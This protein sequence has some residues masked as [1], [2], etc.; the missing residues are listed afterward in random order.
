VSKIKPLSVKE[1]DNID[2]ITK[3]CRKAI[4]EAI[5]N[6]QLSF[7]T[8]R[9]G[10]G[11]LRSLLI[12]AESSQATIGNRNYPVFL[13]TEVNAEL[14]WLGVVLLFGFKDRIQYLESISLVV[15]KGLAFDNKVPILRAEWDCGSEYLEA[16]HGQPHWHIYPSA[17]INKNLESDEILEALTN[18]HEDFNEMPSNQ[19]LPKFH[20]A[21]ATKWHEGS[22]T[23][24]A[25]LEEVSS[26][27]AWLQ[28][29]INYTRQQLIYSWE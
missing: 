2:D 14:F 28:S 10:R 12:G 26:L 29:C 6:R 9:I 21:M 20:F 7:Q 15:V 13:L 16:V 4:G 3:A 11:K 27:T 22:R 25:D 5:T 23:A 24:H 18:P 17:I 1:I 8:E 19:N